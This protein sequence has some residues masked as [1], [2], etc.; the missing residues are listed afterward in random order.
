MKNVHLNSIIQYSKIDVHI[1]EITNVIFE[2]APD[3]DYR[4]VG[5]WSAEPVNG[6]PDLIRPTMFVLDCTGIG[7]L[8]DTDPFDLPIIAVHK[9]QS[10]R[11]V[12]G[13]S[14]QPK[15]KYYRGYSWIADG[16]FNNYESYFMVVYVERINN[17]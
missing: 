1:Q 10:F 9:I 7:V 17:E 8:W 14:R 16:T 15:G 13:K 4:G 6:I 5:S 3:I 11:E 2:P 12:Y